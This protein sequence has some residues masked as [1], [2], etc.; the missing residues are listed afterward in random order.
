[1]MPYC[2]AISVAWIAIVLLWY[3]IGLPLGPG[4]NPVL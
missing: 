4:S 2:I 3:L 1:M